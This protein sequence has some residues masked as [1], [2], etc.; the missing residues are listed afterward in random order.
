MLRS[1]LRLFAVFFPLLFFFSGCIAIGQSFDLAGVILSLAASGSA[2]IAVA[3]VDRRERV[4]A[5]AKPPSFAGVM[6]GSYGNPFDVVVRGKVPL[7]QVTADVIAAG[8]TARGFKARSVALE[9]TADEAAAKA[10]LA[11]AG[12]E[13]LLLIDIEKWESDTMIRIGMLYRMT[14][15]VFDKAG[16]TIAEANVTGAEGGKDVLKGSFMNPY[17]NAK[18][19]IPKAFREQFERLLNADAIVKALA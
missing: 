12:A 10:G 17:G 1:T 7:A 14:A 15:K 2:A 5:G 16:N 9:A 4:R 19:A 11:A 3:A 8:L 13:K 6:R 18:K